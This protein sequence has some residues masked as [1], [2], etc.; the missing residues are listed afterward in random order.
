MCLRPV[1]PA[2]SRL[3]RS[4][5]FRPLS[6]EAPSCGSEFSFAPDKLH[7]QAAH[8]RGLLD[9]VS[10]LQALLRVFSLRRIY[11]VQNAGSDSCPDRRFLGTNRNSRS[12]EHT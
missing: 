11:E 9:S 5:S 6:N 7:E 3:Q 8:F 4:I 1:T 2:I 12:E 10:G